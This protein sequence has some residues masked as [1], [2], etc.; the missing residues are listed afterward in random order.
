MRGW[1]GSGMARTPAAEL[2]TSHASRALSR[3]DWTSAVSSN[4]GPLRSAPF[5]RVGR[6][7]VRGAAGELLLAERHGGRIGDA[8]HDVAS[9]L[10]GLVLQ[11]SE[12]VGVR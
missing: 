1:R 5:T 8:P 2:M 10:A 7:G 3:I 12:A 9:E 4:F 11:R 6:L